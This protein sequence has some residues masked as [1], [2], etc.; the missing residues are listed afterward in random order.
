MRGLLQAR[1]PGPGSLFPRT[2]SPTRAPP[3]RASV[4]LPGPDA[5][6]RLGAFPS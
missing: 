6:H 5:P 2:E 1:I 4:S 3:P